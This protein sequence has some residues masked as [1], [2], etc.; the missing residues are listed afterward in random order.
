[1]K[2][3]EE[4]A[5]EQQLGSPTYFDDP[6]KNRMLATLLS[7]AEEVC[8]LRDRLD[9]SER[10]AAAGKSASAAEVDAYRPSDEL[11]AERLQR[12]QAFF[13]ETLSRLSD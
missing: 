1:M 10:L 13:E 8:V 7:L 11:I 4:I 9:T 12:H 5:A 2:T 6:E 3:L